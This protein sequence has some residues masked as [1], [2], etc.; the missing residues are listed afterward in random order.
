MA[1]LTS[2]ALAL[3]GKRMLLTDR[4]GL[5]QLYGGF[6]GSCCAARSIEQ[7]AFT[8][9]PPAAKDSPWHNSNF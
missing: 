6:K 8:R 4:F 3:A 2:T 5:R 9:Q 1:Y 7:Q